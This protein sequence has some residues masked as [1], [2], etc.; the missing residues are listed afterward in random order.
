MEED[1]NK[2]DDSINNVMSL[3]EAS[4]ESDEVI[5]YTKN[6]M[7]V[8]A[9][10]LKKEL[11][12]SNDISSFLS[13]PSNLNDI[14]SITASKVD[15][16]ISDKP[17]DNNLL[18]AQNLLKTFI[19][20]N[21]NNQGISLPPVL[22]SVNLSGSNV[23]DFV[24]SVPNDADKETVQGK[25]NEILN[26]ISTIYLS[27]INPDDLK[28][29]QNALNKY[30]IHNGDIWSSSHP[31]NGSGSIAPKDSY[32][33][34][35]NDNNGNDTY[36]S[37][38]DDDDDDNDDYGK[39]NDNDNGN[40]DGNDND[41]WPEYNPVDF[42]IPQQKLHPSIAPPHMISKPKSD[43][44]PSET[45]STNMILS[46]EGLTYDEKNAMNIQKGLPFCDYCHKFYSSD[47]IF[48][49]SFKT[50]SQKCY[51]C[52]FWMNYPIDARATVDGVHGGLTIRE[53]IMKCK[54][55]HVTETCPRKSDTG[56]CF[57]CEFNLGMPITDIKDADKLYIH[58]TYNDGMPDHPDD[59]FE[60]P[61]LVAN[62]N[63]E[64][65]EIIVVN[66]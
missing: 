1:N 42:E 54:D 29:L 15:K 66:I 3:I 65:E 30:D 47:M 12:G 38:D 46:T 41:E 58:D 53:Y 64:E 45:V 16:S 17:N 10:T 32:Q 4:G 31:I 63:K 50:Y 25:V 62:N 27:Q 56:G 49:L 23:S 52:L 7:S 55:I 37:T 19:S 22:P 28:E 14:V 9:S 59:D 5:N 6:V 8:V 48:P 18:K 33:Y 61:D 35:N 24:M 60:D 57:L 20:N 2:F 51:H 34:D 13:N 26:K 40:G 44:S 11:H 21:V 36:S 39:D 43:K